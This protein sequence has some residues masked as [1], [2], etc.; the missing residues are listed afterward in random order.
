MKTVYKDKKEGY[1]WKETRALLRDQKTVKALIET[2]FKEENEVLEKLFKQVDLDRVHTEDFSFTR[3]GKEGE[4]LIVEFDLHKKIAKEEN[5]KGFAGKLHKIID[6]NK[7]FQA[8][9]RGQKISQIKIIFNKD[10]DEKNPLIF[11]YS[12][13]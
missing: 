11:K 2:E 7:N 8:D 13:E 10:Y 4:T 9:L 3:F 5:L 1:T 12:V 6:G